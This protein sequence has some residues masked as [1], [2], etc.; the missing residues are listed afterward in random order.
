M[1]QIV[2]KVTNNLRDLLNNSVKSAY[3]NGE[4][5]KDR[6]SNFLIEIPA[7]RNHGDFATNIAMVS[8]KIFRLSPRK[9]AEIIVSN[10]NLDNTMFKKVE[11][12]GPGFIN[13]FLGE[14]F[15]SSILRDIE[16]L[17]NNYGRSNY[18]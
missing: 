14:S 9:I 5:I 17:G 4:L 8:A 3:H 12:A 18:G 16:K 13:F 7:D 10:L 15:Y 2:M 1:S 6:V 11:I